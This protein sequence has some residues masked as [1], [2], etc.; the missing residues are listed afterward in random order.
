MKLII[1]NERATLNI[2]ME[3]FFGTPLKDILVVITFQDL[4]TYNFIFSFKDIFGP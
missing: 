1:V 4:S 3:T 2:T